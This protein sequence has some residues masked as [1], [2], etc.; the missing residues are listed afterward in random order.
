MAKMI[1]SL[2]IPL[3]KFMRSLKKG[4]GLTVDHVPYGGRAFGPIVT[5]PP[6]QNFIHDDASGAKIVTKYAPNTV[7]YVLLGLQAPHA[8]ELKK[9]QRF[10]M[11][12]NYSPYVTDY[13]VFNMALAK[14]IG[15]V[16]SS[17]EK[18]T[19]GIYVGT[20]F[21]IISTP[22]AKR[23]FKGISGEFGLDRNG[24]NPI[25]FTISKD[26]TFKPME[27]IYIAV[28]VRYADFGA[29]NSKPMFAMGGV[30]VNPRNDPVSYMFPIYEGYSNDDGTI[31]DDNGF[32]GKPFKVHNGPSSS[33]E[34]ARS[35][36]QTISGWSISDRGGTGSIGSSTTPYWAITNTFLVEV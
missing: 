22:M 12:L 32:T 30:P 11:R 33:T 9:G 2:K 18:R 16:S 5:E 19:E 8:M 25:V 27:Y 13:A 23:S 4:N 3:G 35:G 28:A 10:E 15:H 1:E 34:L 24:A 14:G 26:V 31:V 29:D 36:P 17:E 21:D 6:N 20:S 7:G